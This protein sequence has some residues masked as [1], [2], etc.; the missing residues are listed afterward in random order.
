MPTVKKAVT[1]VKAEVKRERERDLERAA[2]WRKANNKKARCREV[3]AEFPNVSQSA[4]RRRLEQKVVIGKP[5]EAKM[6]LTY[7]EEDQLV[8]WLR[9]C[10]AGGQPKKRT[11]ISAKIVH[12]LKL[13]T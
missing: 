11:Q 3:T 8:R 1:A 7:D 6:L 9:Q 4:L 12:F 5:N 2:T 10:K 13:K